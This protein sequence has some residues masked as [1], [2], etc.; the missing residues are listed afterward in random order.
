M[1]VSV[2]VNLISS[3]LIMIS[4]VAREGS[5]ALNT[6]LRESRFGLEI[7]TLRNLQNRFLRDSII[8]HLNR[9]WLNMAAETMGCIK[10]VIS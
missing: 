4:Q 9:I 7:F 10:Q 8:D 6:H 3:G 5:L 1:V 2:I